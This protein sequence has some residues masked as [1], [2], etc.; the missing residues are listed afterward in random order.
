LKGAPGLTGLG[1]APRLTYWVHEGKVYVHRSGLSRDALE[2]VARRLTGPLTPGQ[3]PMDPTLSGQP[4]SL[5]WITP[6]VRQFYEIRLTG[7]VSG[8]Q[9]RSIWMAAPISWNRAIHLSGFADIS[10][11][12]LEATER[13]NMFID[14]E[15]SQWLSAAT[16]NVNSP[17]LGDSNAI[18]APSHVKSAGT[19]DPLAVAR[20]RGVQAKR[21][22]LVAQ[23]ELLSAAEAAVRLGVA[24]DEVAL[25]QFQRQLLAL[26]L[27]AGALGFP[28][29]QFTDTG[30]LSGLDVVLH[31]LGVHDPW[32][33]AA[34]FLSSDLR[35]GGRTPLEVL[36]SGDVEAVRRAGVAYGEQLA[37]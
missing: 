11:H 27:G 34:F 30:L 31:D 17:E 37:S 28:S 16:R 33:S 24:A 32:M 13:P 19:P 18:A 26:P 23:G 9:Q 25:R 10:I 15:W 29:W 3:G 22:I 36:L 7:D 21:D 12:L 8:I 20:Q 35:L 14:S 6:L 2:W 5:M 4:P 1:E